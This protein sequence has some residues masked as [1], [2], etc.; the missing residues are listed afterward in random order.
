[1]KGKNQRAT[2]GGKGDTPRPVQGDK[3]RDNYDS[4]FRKKANDSDAKKP[5]HKKAEN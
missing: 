5:T 2:E 4:I 3:Y 1:M